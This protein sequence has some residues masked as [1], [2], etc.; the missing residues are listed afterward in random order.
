MYKCGDW[1]KTALW[2]ICC[3]ARRIFTGFK[4]AK[5]RTHFILVGLLYLCGVSISQECRTKLRE[6]MNYVGSYITS[7][8]SPDVEHCQQ[9]C[10]QHPSCL[11]FTFDQSGRNKH[12]YCY[13]KSSPSG[14]PDVR[15]RRQ[16]V[17]SG[18]SLKPCTPVPEPC[19]SQVYQ[20]VDFPGAD[21][22][23]LFTADY[24]E[25]QR[26][27]THDPTCHFFTFNNGNFTSGE[28][29]YKCQLK[30]SWTVPR[31]ARLEAK[32]GL[33]SGF[34]HKI[35]ISQQYD[36]ACPTTLFLNTDIPGN[37]MDNLPAASPEHC[38]TLCTAHPQCTCFSYTRL[39]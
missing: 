12:F 35:Q 14:Q 29:R 10:T 37:E 24:E 30:F 25:C 33:V 4:S 26:A 9:L 13:L 3:G 31:I 32:A 18:F 5:M 39:G 22:E 15:R 17:T 7:L 19:L 27:C 20:N 11:F 23:T 21:Y 38:H 6:N 2:S 16:G 34:S 1:K 8:Y 36:T 28:Y